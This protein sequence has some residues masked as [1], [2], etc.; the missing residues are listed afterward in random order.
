MKYLVYSYLTI[1][2]TNT[3]TGSY[4]C[5]FQSNVILRI[6]HLYILSILCRIYIYMY[7]A[8]ESVRFLLMNG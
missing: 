3:L 1:C 7:I 6:L 5:I 8:Y 4:Y 2:K